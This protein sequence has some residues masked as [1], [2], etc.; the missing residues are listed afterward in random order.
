MKHLNSSIKCYRIADK[1]KE[2]NS[3]IERENLLITHLVNLVR[4]K[5]GC[6]CGS[7]EFHKN[8]QTEVM[9]NRRSEDVIWLSINKSHFETEF[10]KNANFISKSIT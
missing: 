2:D 5:F 3:S 10:A 8:T 9:L 1:T 6:K 7:C 4:A